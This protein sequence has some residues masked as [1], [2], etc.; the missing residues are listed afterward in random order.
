MTDHQVLSFMRGN[1]DRGLDPTDPGPHE[2]AF[3]VFL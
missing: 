1:Q 3:A 2:A